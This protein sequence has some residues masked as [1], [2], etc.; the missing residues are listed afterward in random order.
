MDAREQRPWLVYGLAFA[1]LFRLQE[2]YGTD[3]N[4]VES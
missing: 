3:L 4:Y 2:T 1:A